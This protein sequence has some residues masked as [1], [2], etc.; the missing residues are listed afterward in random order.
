[1]IIITGA[2]GFIGSNLVSALNKLGKTDLVLVDELENQAK[3]QNISHTKFKE[4]IHRDD[5]IEWLQKN[6]S[7]ISFIFHLG[8]RTDTTEQDKSIFDKL[9]F[10]YSK[11]I[12]E[13]CTKS[14]IPLLYA[15]SA[16]TYG[17]GSLGYDDAIKAVNLSALNPYG[18]SKLAFDKWV[19]NQTK[20]PPFWVGLKFFN[21]YGPHEFHK[22]RMSSVVYHAFKQIQETGKM[23]LFQSHKNGIKN[24]EQQRDFIYVKD[25]V[26]VCLY[27][28][29]TQ[30]NSGIY[31]LG[32]GTART[33]NDLAK[34][35]FLALNKE[36][37]IEYIPTPIDIR[38]AYQYFTEAKMDKLRHTG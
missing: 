26:D 28:Y 11:S 27:F 16:A 3:N 12:F 33:F 6:A 17:N 4:L 34:A 35:V 30:K 24:G 32:T 31:N 7:K 13:I 29:N 8:A 21:V 36:P 2:R 15:S 37:I 20:T 10:N 1:M 5:F 18:E 23:R 38:D 25:V 14:N 19:E 22:N 9:N